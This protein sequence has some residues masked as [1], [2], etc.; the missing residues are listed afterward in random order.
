MEL[1]IPITIFAAFCQNLRSALQ[2]YLK[3]K[4]NTSGAT[5]SR[6]LYATPLAALYAFGLAAVFGYPVPEPNAAFAVY[7]V[8]GGLAQ[9]IATA[10]LLYLFGFR[11]FAVG[12]T[13]SKTETIQT[14][15]FGIVILGDPIGVWATIAIL[16]SLV[17][18]MAI[19]VARTDIGPRS[20]LTSL[21]EKTALIGIASGSFFGISAVAYRGASLSLGGEGFLMQ[22]AFTLA[23]VTL[24]Q[25]LVMSVYMRLRE[26]GEITKVVRSWKVAGLVGL[27]GMLGSA[28]WFT[29]MTIQNAA[30]VRALGTDRA[31]VHL[32]RLLLLL[33]REDK[34]GRADRHFFGDRRDSVAAA[35]LIPTREGKRLHRQADRA[36]ATGQVTHL[37]A[38][39]V[40]IEADAAVAILDIHLLVH[41]MQA[42]HGHAVRPPRQILNGDDVGLF[43]ARR[44]GGG[45]GRQHHMGGDHPILQVLPEHPFGNH[46][47][48]VLPLA[49]HVFG[50]RS[51]GL[52]HA[53]DIDEL[54]LR[55]LARHTREDASK[56]GRE[57]ASGC[58]ARSHTIISRTAWPASR[59]AARAAPERAVICKKPWTTR[60]YAS[61]L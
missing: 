46:Q 47:I 57:P 54:I 28:G 25:T 34:P 17:G 3:G 44:G 38:R 11:N 5:F 8:I 37:A 55:R 6:F 23:C 14:A 56:K 49:G 16:V 52:R 22:A 61:S 26:P 39:H 10:L 12:T 19:S 13:Y 42:G 51:L 20:L 50:Q 1:W 29:A 41:V 27:S 36:K 31:R 33:P 15:I 30:Y 40:F 21:T 4:L 2:K 45:A 60:G 48:E 18:V 53:V 7:A 59:M 43:V 32:R 58:G 35:G 9:I 24:F